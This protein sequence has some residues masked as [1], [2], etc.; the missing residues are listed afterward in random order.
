MRGGGCGGGGGRMYVA[1]RTTLLHIKRLNKTESPIFFL[2]C[3]LCLQRQP[4]RLLF[5]IPHIA[6]E[7]F[8]GT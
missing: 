5:I 3:V 4:F 8:E 6:T 1:S 7:T 2:L